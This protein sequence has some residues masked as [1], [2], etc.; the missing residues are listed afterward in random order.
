MILPQ[1][2]L[3]TGPATALQP[4][5]PDAHPIEKESLLYK[6]VLHPLPW[7]DDEA[8]MRASPVTS[9]PQAL[10]RLRLWNRL[11]KTWRDKPRSV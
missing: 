2:Q 6:L 9:T 5:S 11:T 4:V 3:L 7:K 1:F 8:F 10:E